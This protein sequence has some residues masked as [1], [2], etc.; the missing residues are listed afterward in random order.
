MLLASVKGE[1]GHQA[2]ARRRRR[3][4]RPPATAA[5]PALKERPR[6][7]KAEPEAGDATQTE[8]TVTDTEDVGPAAKA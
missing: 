8:D 4:P 2:R 3:P 7:T 1:V 6:T 5:A